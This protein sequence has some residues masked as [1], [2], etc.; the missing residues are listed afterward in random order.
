MKLSLPKLLDMPPLWLLGFAVLLWGLG[1]VLPLPTGSAFLQG[2]GTALV[3]FGIAVVLLAGVQFR[4]HRTTIIPHQQA[5]HL[6][7]TG[8]FG[9]SRNPIY[10]ADSAILGGLAL[11]WD[12][13]HGLVLVPIFVLILQRRFIL[14]EEQRLLAGFGDDFVAYQRKVRRWL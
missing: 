3:V 13:P 7:D 9:W 10:L 12:I 5:T 11:R 8:V 4:R 2:L 6:L 1:Q 14:P